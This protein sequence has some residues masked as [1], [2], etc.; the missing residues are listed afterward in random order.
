ME[1]GT[2]R[3]RKELGEKKLSKRNLTLAPLENNQLMRFEFMT[4]LLY[5]LLLCI[6][7]R[8]PCYNT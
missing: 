4:H 2:H 1:S 7:S 8:I 6:L 5:F 3:N